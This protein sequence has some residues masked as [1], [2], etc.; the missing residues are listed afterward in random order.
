MEFFKKL[1]N[2]NRKERDEQLQEISKRLGI[3]EE[4]TKEKKQVYRNRI[5][6]GTNT[7][8]VFN[9]GDTL[10]CEDKDNNFYNYCAIA[11]DEQDI[12]LT[13]QSI[14][15]KEEIIKNKIEE[16]DLTIL[17]NNPD[18]VINGNK[19]Y[20][21][22]INIP[23]PD[24][25]LA[26]IIYNRETVE[27]SNKEEKDDMYNR[28]IMFWAKLANSPVK[29]RDNVM[30][31]L[32]KND[33]R[34]SKTGNIIAYRNVVKCNT[35][36][37]ENKFIDFINDSYNKVKSWKKSPAKFTIGYNQKEYKLFREDQIAN[38]EWVNMGL[39]STLKFKYSEKKEEEQLYT[40][41]HNPNKYVFTIPSLYKIYED[42]L[43]PNSLNC[44]SG[45]A[46]FSACSWDYSSFGDTKI[47]VLVNPAKAIHVPNYDSGKARTSEM[48]IACI[49]SNEHGVHI[50]ESLIEHADKIYNDMTVEQLK[51]AFASKSMETLSIDDEHIPETS[52]KDV[53]NI[54]N[55][56]SQRVINI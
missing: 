10:T 17:R 24:S 19:T 53:S 54:I 18:F 49:N 38:E 9:N 55:I 21:K 16:R 15:N 28:Y 26:E 56:L 13:Y 46:H 41:W 6:V 50:D 8:I 44:S 33:V 47:V 43:D 4:Q 45:G 27:A 51:E 12:R 22:G 3:I 52:L 2:W 40:T 25:I 7:I 32:L 35:V 31:F 39:L 30:S 11:I 37:V 36:N 42:E 20:L 48:Y 34:L 23:I 29:D 1:F 14:V 5:K